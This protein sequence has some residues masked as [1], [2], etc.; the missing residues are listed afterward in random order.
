MAAIGIDSALASLKVTDLNISVRA[1]NCLRAE[2]I[3]SVTELMNKSDEQL[4][5][6]PNFGLKSLYEVKRAIAELG[7]HTNEVIHQSEQESINGLVDKANSIIDKNKNKKETL[8]LRANAS[9]LEDEVEYFV[10]LKGKRNG[11]IVKTR[12][13]LDGSGV[14]TLQETGELF[15]LTRERV[16]QICNSVL[17]LLRKKQIETPLLQ[18]TIDTVNKYIP[19]LADEIEAQLVAEGLTQIQFRIDGLIEAAN[20]FFR[21]VPFAIMTIGTRRYVV[22]K[23]MENLPV[24]VNQISRKSIEHWGVATI[25]DIVDQIDKGHFFDLLAEPMG[26]RAVI[27]C[28]RMRDDFRW[29]DEQHGWFWLSSV[30]RNRVLNQ[31]QKILSV[32]RRINVSELRSGVSRNYRMEGFAP[33]SRVLLELSRQDARVHSGKR[34][35]RGESS[36]RDARC[37]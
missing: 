31:I 25:A 17:G 1:L 24:I 29:L 18:K 5:R 9:F 14:K 20:I 30:P 12:Y 4:L 6:L 36:A 13:G 22:P 27:N 26:E 32:A 33:P 19:G 21:E 34:S 3:I 28:L 16:R 35:N 23:G 15:R 7:L 8:I 10:S 2:N 37:S 11:D